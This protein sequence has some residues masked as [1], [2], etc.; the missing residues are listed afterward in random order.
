MVRKGAT[1]S[2]TTVIFQVVHYHH[3]ASS[4]ICVMFINLQRSVTSALLH[5]R[6]FHA[7]DFFAKGTGYTCTVFLLFYSCLVLPLSTNQR[8]PDCFY[9]VPAECSFVLLV[10]SMYTLAGHRAH[11]REQ[12][13]LATERNCIGSRFVVEHPSEQT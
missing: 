4:A 5:C 11:L 3:C 12:P 10:G 1:K 6:R 2:K 7:R 8:R 9:L 13:L